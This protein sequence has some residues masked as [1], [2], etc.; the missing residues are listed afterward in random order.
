MSGRTRLAVYPPDVLRMEQHH[1]LVDEMRPEVVV[2]TRVA[3]HRQ[4]G[5]VLLE[6][7]T[8]SVGR[9]ELRLHV[10]VSQSRC[11]S[12]QLCTVAQFRGQWSLAPT[13]A[14]PRDTQTSCRICFAVGRSCVT[15]FVFALNHRR[16]CKGS[17]L[18]HH[19]HPSYCLL[20]S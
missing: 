16:C 15:A 19:C 5:L 17:G 10:A 1:L 3:A 7:S 9:P 12:E 6:D 20:M 2:F 14:R 13:L 11:S 8:A 18:Y 4:R